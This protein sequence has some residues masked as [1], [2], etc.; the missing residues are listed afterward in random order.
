MEGR[1]PIGA[2]TWDSVLTPDMRPY[3][4]WKPKGSS[5]RVE[6]RPG[7][8][9][10]ALYAPRA[11]ASPASMRLR[12]AS[13]T[14]SAPPCAHPHGARS[15]C[16]YGCWWGATISFFGP[17]KGCSA[18]LAVA[19]SA[20]PG[21][22]FARDRLSGAPPAPAG[23]RNTHSPAGVARA[24]EP[25]FPADAGIWAVPHGQL[26]NVAPMPKCVRARP[27]R[28]NESARQR[29]ILLRRRGARTPVSDRARALGAHRLR[30]EGQASP[31]TAAPNRTAPTA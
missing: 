24:S 29:S 3:A 13:G 16:S 10:R 4:V 12:G 19:G 26:D 11:P 27:R 18:A 6:L 17:Q 25:G 14:L 31:T 21:P 28:T 23:P 2:E 15:P 8:G 30:L 22:C 9:F 7:R 20:T 1:E 5:Q